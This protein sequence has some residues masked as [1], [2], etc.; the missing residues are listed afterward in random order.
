M[1]SK[2]FSSSYAAIHI[3]NLSKK[4]ALSSESL[5]TGAGSRVREE[6]ILNCSSEYKRSEKSG[7]QE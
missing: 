4:Y 6:S 5:E 3:S 2:S 1:S 7:C